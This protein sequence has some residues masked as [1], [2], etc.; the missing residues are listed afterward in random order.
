MEH[1]LSLPTHLGHSLNGPELTHHSHSRRSWSLSPL[2]ICHGIVSKPREALSQPSQQ[3]W[4]PG[5]L[6]CLLVPP[7]R[8]RHGW[9]PKSTCSWEGSELKLPETVFKIESKESSLT[10][11]LRMG[12][13]RWKPSHSPLR[14]SRPSVGTACYRVM[15]GTEL[16]TDTTVTSWLPLTWPIPAVAGG[17]LLSS[18]RLVLAT[19]SALHWD[20]CGRL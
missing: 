11:A 20:D 7:L 14:C 1:R 3:R 16:P 9:L 15:L 13:P 12:L 2:S 4:I 10:Y 6:L 17:C 8:P 19:D 5:S 18:S